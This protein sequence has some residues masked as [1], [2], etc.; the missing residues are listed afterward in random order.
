MEADLLN[1]LKTVDTPTVCNAIE[2]AEGRRGFNRFTRGTMLSSDPTSGAMVGFARTARISALAPPTEPADV[3]KARRM[4]YYRHMSE[5]PRPAL[6]VVE[7]IDYPNAIGAY[8]GE[9]NTTVHK[10]LGLSGALTNGVMRDLGDLPDGFPVV[11]GSV[12]PSHGFVHVREIDTPVRIFGLDIHPGELVHADRHGAL[13][14]P[15]AV[16]PDLAEAIRKLL[17]TEH[18]VLGPAREPGFTFEKFEAAWAAFE[19]ART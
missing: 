18:L 9:I 8:W 12:G 1:L 11:A 13:V 19:R 14:I 15:A 3:I 5:G 2:V 4:D 6:A 10:G 7:D 17:D 16:M